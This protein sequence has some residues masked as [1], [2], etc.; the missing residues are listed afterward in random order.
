LVIEHG[1]NLFAICRERGWDW[2]EV[3]DMSASIN[4]LGPSSKV[5]PA[6]ERALDMIM[7][8]PGQTPDELEQALASG[9][10]VPANSVLAGSGA[11]ELL[12][13]V[14]RA[15]WK[16][17]TTLITPVWSEFYRAFPHALRIP[18]GDPELW[19][20]RGLLVLSQ[21]V[22]PTGEPVPVELIRRVVTSREGPVLIDETFIDFTRLP[23]AAQWVEDNPNLLVLRS[24]SKFHALPG[25]RVGAVVGSGEWMDRLRRRR[26]P[27]QVST[28]AEAAAR[29]AL[30][31]LDHAERTRELV[32]EER[33]Y[34][35]DELSEMDGVRCAEGVANFL[36]A[37]TQRRAKD[38][39]DWFLERKILLRN[40]TGLPGV[41][42]EAIRFAV[43]T[44]DE[45]DRFLDAAEEFFCGD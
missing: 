42:G 23:S 28:L 35:L 22:N 15:G 32:E 43:R 3:L 41:Q 9:W 36:F 27:W 2:Q 29:A 8:Y 1:G 45:N 5:R 4:P 33:E 13:F 11:T 25:L 14:A 7:H 39:C 12:H 24:L 37:Q 6:V 26:E 40:C 44:R 16:G 19:P 21:P 31:D 17:P 10:N 20:Q 34:M 30:S 38:I 18:M